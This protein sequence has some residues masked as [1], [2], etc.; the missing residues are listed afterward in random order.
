MPH[1]LNSNFPVRTR[2]ATSADVPAIIPLVNA[3]FAVETFLDG[4]RTD[5]ERMT[6]MMQR[7][8][9][10]VAEEEPGQL[11]ATVYIERRND[12]RGHF[13]MLAVDP[14]RQGSGIGRVMIEA[15]ED[16][17]RE[18]V[19][20]VGNGSEGFDVSPDGKES[21]VANAQ[22][23]TVSIIDVLRKKVTQTL[24][25]DVGGA[26]RLKFT[27]DGKLALVSTLGGPNLTVIDAS[28]RKTIKR[29]PVGHGAAGIVVQPD[30]LRAFVACS[31]DGYVAF[32]DLHSLEQ[33]GRIEIGKDPDGM[34]WVT[35]H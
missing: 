30:G 32:V 11:V 17:C 21:W 9:F 20:P 33:V 25:A 7:G 2:I 3:A 12:G 18:T 13:G 22:D 31:P 14:L 24:A 26:N 8:E 6:T 4:T 16:R 15:A 10:L 23:G 28:T 34:A 19:V 5:R 27:A 29:I 35:R 1:A